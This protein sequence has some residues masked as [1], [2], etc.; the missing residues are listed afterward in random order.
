MGNENSADEVA[1]PCFVCGKPMRSA[2][3]KVVT[4]DGAQIVSAG[5][6]CYRHAVKHE[7][8]GGYATGPGLVKVLPYRGAR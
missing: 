7:N 4:E 1:E 8:T 2:R 6:D 5:R 3:F